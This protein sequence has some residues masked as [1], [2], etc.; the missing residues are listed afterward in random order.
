MIIEQNFFN[1]KEF[2]DLFTKRF[3]SF[4]EKSPLFLRFTVLDNSVLVYDLSTDPE[5]KPVSFQF[6]FTMSDKGN[7]RV[8]KDYLVENCYPTFTVIEVTEK[9]PTAFDIQDMMVEQKLSFKAA[10]MKTVKTIKETKYRVEKVFNSDN[11]IAV[12]KDGDKFQTELHEL[13]IP[14]TI[15]MREIFKNPENAADIFKNKSTFL[16]AVVDKNQA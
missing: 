16:H 11:R 15:F 12:R 3:S 5:N 4:C 1:K 14:I 13:K 8:I 6:D 2:I 9:Q 7:I 10:S